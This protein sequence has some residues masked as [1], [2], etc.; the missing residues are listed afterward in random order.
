MHR[1]G[2][3]LDLLLQLE[4]DLAQD[5]VLEPDLKPVGRKMLAA[6]E[7]DLDKRLRR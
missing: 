5:L 2:L 3:E 7:I 6:E 1:L 4:Q